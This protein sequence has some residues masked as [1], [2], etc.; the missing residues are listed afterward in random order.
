MPEPG[1][2]LERQLDGLVL[3]VKGGI[4]EARMRWQPW[5]VALGARLVS[6]VF[7]AERSIADAAHRWRRR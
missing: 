2:A 7:F 1:G 4:A 6:L 3:L 5:K